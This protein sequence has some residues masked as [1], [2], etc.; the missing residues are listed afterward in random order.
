MHIHLVQPDE[1]SARALAD[2]FEELGHDVEVD[3]S[4][5][6]DV[7]D[8]TPDALVVCLDAAPETALERA[9]VLAER[10][11]LRS[12][13][14]LFAGGTEHWLTEAQR[15]FPRASFARMDVLHNAVA[16]LRG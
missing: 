6:A 9:A 15:R 5:A 2:D 16:S 1:A 11:R 8:G 12:V 14:L 7:P 4:T 13:P 10:R 3:E